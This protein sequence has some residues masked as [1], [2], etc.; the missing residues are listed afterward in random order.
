MPRPRSV[1]A[2]VPLTVLL[3]AATVGASHP[4][5]SS[6]GHHSSH[7]SYSIHRARTYRSPS[8]Q[9][10]DMVDAALA[11]N[12]EI[13]KEGFDNHRKRSHTKPNPAGLWAVRRVYA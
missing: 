9:L 5:T 10:R 11:S 12:R 2:F 1:F 6:R 4:Q 8:G 3:L 13:I 7:R